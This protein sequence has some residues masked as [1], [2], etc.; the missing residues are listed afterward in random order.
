MPG[1]PLTL[2][3]GSS[4]NLL[5]ADGTSSSEEAMHAGSL[6][7]GPNEGLPIA[8]QCTSASTDELDSLEQSFQAEEEV[9]RA[10]LQ[11]FCAEMSFTFICLT[12][13]AFILSDQPA[14]YDIGTWRRGVQFNTAKPV[15]RIC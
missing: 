1:E 9:I 15:K 4:F 12:P 3:D 10:S 8:G 6:K 2:C 5:S 7:R 13:A 14:R 11:I